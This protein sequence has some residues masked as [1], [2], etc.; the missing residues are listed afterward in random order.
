MS[1]PSVHL[2]ICLHV[3]PCPPLD[4]FP[5]HLILITSVKSRE[6]PDFVK[7][8]QEYKTPYVNV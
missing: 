8:W 5:S 3:S 4:G 2:T 1:C 6:N 7:I